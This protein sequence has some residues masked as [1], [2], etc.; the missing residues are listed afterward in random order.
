MWWLARDEAALPADP[1][2]LSPGEVRRAAR[3][4][5]P[6]RRTGY[7]LRRLAVKHAVAA[8]ADLPT[9]PAT[10]SRI[11]VANAPSGAPY[12][13]LDGAPAGLAVSVSDRAGWAVCVVGTGTVGCDVELVEPR[14]PA[15]VRDFLTA[16]EQ[17]YVAGAADRDEAANLV[18]S[19]KES[20]LKVL[21][22]GLRRDTRS[23]EVTVHGGQSSG[24]APLAVRTVEG[25]RFPGWWRRDGDLLLTMVSL[26]AGLPPTALESPAPFLAPA[27]R[28]DM[29]AA[30]AAG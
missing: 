30:R 13:L 12:L 10:L 24:W 11:E 16:A 20:A 29:V 17:A 28:R 27:R 25:W 1:S 26:V 3:L 5:Y 18:W 6:R 9:D 4:Y 14:S 21:R 22:T 7:L 8:V 15:F 19:A 2:W 23:V